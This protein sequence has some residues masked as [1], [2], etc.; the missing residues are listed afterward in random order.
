MA[1]WMI[2][3]PSN[4]K[5]WLVKA[6]IGSSAYDVGIIDSS[7]ATSCSREE[8]HPTAPGATAAKRPCSSLVD[9][10]SGLAGVSSTALRGPE[11]LRRRTGVLRAAPDS[12]SVASS[13]PILSM[14]MG[15]SASLD[16]DGDVL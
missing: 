6:E 10:R 11:D 9:L 7:F 4:P 1:P 13:S 14:C 8:Q 16:F 2:C 15:G 12:S 5:A 3:R